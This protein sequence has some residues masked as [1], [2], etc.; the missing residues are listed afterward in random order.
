MKNDK[1]DFIIEEMK[2]EKNTVRKNMPDSD[3]GL[4]LS[5]C[6]VKVLL[7]SVLIAIALHAAI[8]AAHYV[9]QSIQQ[10]MNERMSRVIETNDNAEQRN[11]SLNDFWIDYIL[12]GD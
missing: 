12:S 10:S 4:K 8:H 5:G 7:I 9:Q 11:N 3:F 6:C 1:K 2:K